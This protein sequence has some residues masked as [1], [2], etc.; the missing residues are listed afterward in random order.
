M[1][2]RSEPHAVELQNLLFPRARRDAQLVGRLRCVPRKRQ[3]ELQL[4]AALPVVEP[5]LLGLKLWDS[6]A[7]ADSRS[8]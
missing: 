4:S 6:S 8:V 1:Q 2:Q 5:V 7:F 3:Y